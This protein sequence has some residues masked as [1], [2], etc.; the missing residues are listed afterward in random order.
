MV[1][2]MVAATGAGAGSRVLSLGC[3]IGDTELL[4]A[5]RVREVVGVDFSPAAIRQAREDAAGAGVKNARFVEG[6]AECA[7]EGPYD[8]VVA[9][10][11]LHHLPEEELR[12]LPALVR[13]LL[14]PGGRFYSLDPSRYRLSGAVGN[15]VVPRLMRKYQS[16]GERELRRRETAALFEGAGFACRSGYYDFVSSPLAGLLPGWGWGYRTARLL[17]EAL[18]RTPGLRAL[19]SNFEVIARV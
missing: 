19:G 9:I 11:F 18:I 6:A 7:P 5:R 13:R 1:R 8:A 14:T 17:D 2:R 16:P 12:G 10:F 15:L 4:L 3:G